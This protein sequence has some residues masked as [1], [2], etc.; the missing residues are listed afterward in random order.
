MKDRK[1]HLDHELSRRERQIMDVIYR[2]GKASVAEVAEKVPDPPSASAIRAA[3]NILAKKKLVVSKE[4]GPR[5]IYY[6]A[7]KKEAIRGN[8]M[9][10]VLKTYFEGSV[11]LAMASLIDAVDEDLSD[12]ELNQIERMIKKARQ[13]GR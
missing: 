7:V 2:E 10:H 8:A 13:E 1:K 9:G 6:P 3:L 4:D 5:K 12:D 11:S